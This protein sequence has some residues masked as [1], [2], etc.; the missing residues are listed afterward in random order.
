MLNSLNHIKY[1]QFLFL[2]WCVLRSR[3]LDDCVWHAT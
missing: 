3:W 1:V 2:V